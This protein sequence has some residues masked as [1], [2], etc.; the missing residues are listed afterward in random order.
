MKTFSNTR[1]NNLT[2]IPNFL[3][4]LKLILIRYLTGK[5]FLVF[6][7]Y[8]ILWRLMRSMEIV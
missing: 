5:V 1:I 4:S 7:M 6:L 8:L 2:G 3:N